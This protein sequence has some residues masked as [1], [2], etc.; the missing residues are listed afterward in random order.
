MATNENKKERFYKHPQYGHVYGEMLATPV[1]RACWVNLTKPKDP[2]P[3]KEGQ[4]P[5]KPR[6]EVTFLLDKKDKT[7]LGFLENLREMT[8]EMVKLFNKKR[9]TLIQIESVLKDGDEFDLEKYPMYEDQLLLVGRNEAQIECVARNK[10]IAIETKDILAG[11]LCKGVVTPMVTSHGVSFKLHTI[12]LIKDDG[13]R[14]GTTRPDAKSYLDMID[15][16][17]AEEATPKKT[18][19]ASKAVGGKENAKQALSQL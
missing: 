18:N 1:G 4:A 3:P 12:Q 16:E 5:G 13:V 11:M 6:F 15:E 9:P 8:T 7:V 2:P 14:F 19:G 10:E 17:P